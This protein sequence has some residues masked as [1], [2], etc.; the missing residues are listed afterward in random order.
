MSPA[1]GRGGAGFGAPCPWVC[2]LCCVAKAKG[3]LCPWMS[4]PEQE[5]AVQGPLWS[6]VSCVRNKS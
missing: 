3:H 4:Q 1:A 5:G 2:A 6:A